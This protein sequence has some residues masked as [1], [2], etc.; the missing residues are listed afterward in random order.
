MEVHFEMV[1]SR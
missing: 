1:E